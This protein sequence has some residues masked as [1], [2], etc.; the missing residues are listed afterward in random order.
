MENTHVIQICTIIG[1]RQRAAATVVN[2]QEELDIYCHSW[3]SDSGS[4]P[5]MTNS[6]ALVK[7]IS[8]LPKS[9]KVK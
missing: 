3:W 2:E 6:F 7:G 8:I 9:Y 4:P 1:L 5:S